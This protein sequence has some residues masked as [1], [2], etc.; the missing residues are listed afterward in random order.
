M[1]LQIGV[2][3]C[4]GISFSGFIQQHEF[5][6]LKGPYLGQKPPGMTAEIFA[7]G[8]VSTEEMPEMCAAFTADGREFYYNAQY[9]NR[10]AIYLTREVNGQWSI[11][12]P[13]PFTSGYT[14]RDFTMSP[15]GQR[16]YFGSNRPSEKRKEQLKALDIYVTERIAGVSWSEP[17]NVGHVINSDQGENYP[18]VAQN[19]NLY[20]FSSRADGFGGCDIYFSRYIDGRYLAP[21]NLGS[22]INSAQNDWDAFIAPD[23]SYIIFSSQ[24]RNDTLGGQDLY[25]S[26]QKDRRWTAAVN[27]GPNVN[28]ESGEIC[29]S[30]SL[31]GR[32]LF[33][34]SRRRGKADIFW[35]KTDIIKKLKPKN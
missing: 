8:I 4:I 35:I 32:Y 30:V 26:F 12:E 1:P 13:M 33:F 17:V 21:E 16:I 11:P 14:D 19:G 2:L 31:D 27:I 25:I 15:D 5:P 28:S 9:K 20:F 23:E 7:P 6:V 24:D 18:S 3:L 34:T 22:E 10:W 29:P